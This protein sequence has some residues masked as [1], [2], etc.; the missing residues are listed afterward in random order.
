[1]VCEA[2]NGDGCYDNRILMVDKKGRHGFAGCA[3]WLSALVLAGM[4]WRLM[5]LLMVVRKW[6]TLWVVKSLCW[7]LRRRRCLYD[8]S[9]GNAA[10]YGG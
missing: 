8:T 9:D 2:L 5:C 4:M 1:M 6:W 7:M 3:Y 10:R